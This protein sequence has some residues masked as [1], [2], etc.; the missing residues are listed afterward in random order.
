MT[1]LGLPTSRSLTGI[2]VL[3]V[4]ALTAAV[5]GQQQDYSDYQ[6]YGDY[7]SPDP[8]DN[9]Y[10]DYAARQETKGG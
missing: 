3:L 9:L 5:F 2:S 1:I 7:G 8:Q 10:A 6:D 4:L